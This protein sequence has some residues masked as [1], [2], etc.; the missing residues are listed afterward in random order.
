MDRNDYPALYKSADSTSNIVQSQYLW[1]MRGEY[2]L[3]IV[4][5]IL[6]M[7]W[8]TSVWYYV[9]FA[10]V[11]LGAGA[12]LLYRSIKKPD[13]DWYRARAL[14]ESIKT[15]TWRYM[16][17]AEPFPDSE[18]VQIPRSNF[19]SY[20]KGILDAN[21]HI[22]DRLAEAG[23]DGDEVTSAMDTV[24]RQN[25]DERKAEYIRARVNE[26][27]TWYRKKAADNRRAFKRWLVA[28]LVVYAFAI[29]SVLI[30]IAQPTW[31][32]TPTEPLIVL[33]SSF[34]GWMQ[35]KKFNE[36]AS[37]YALTAHEIGIIQGKVQEADGE[38]KF[39]EFVNEAELA[40]SRE[41]TQWVARQQEP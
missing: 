33:A 29:V 7:G 22:G 38:E 6:S 15:S 31:G 26:Q 39:S 5:A 16:M 9:A 41:H 19:R 14:A 36:L 10:C 34:I 20:L 25:L 11:F 13:R 8:S 27:K 4:A 3:L 12:T 30:R 21:S 23:S 32:L 17:R 18:K 40:F 2:A 37:A 28:C 24:R 35:L 1:L